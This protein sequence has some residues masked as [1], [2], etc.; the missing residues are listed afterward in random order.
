MDIATS[1]AD[2]AQLKRLGMAIHYGKDYTVLKY[3]DATRY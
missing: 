2:E 3:G 1:D